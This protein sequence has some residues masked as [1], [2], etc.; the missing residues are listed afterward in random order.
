MDDTLKKAIRR[1]MNECSENG[2]GYAT[3]T[4]ADGRYHCFSK[5]RLQEFLKQCE[6]SGQDVVLVFVPD[7]ILAADLPD[8]N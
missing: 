8:A 3:M 1:V 6:D 2:T 7:G 5:K 4:M